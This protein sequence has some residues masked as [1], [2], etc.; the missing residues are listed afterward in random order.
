[1][2]LISSKDQQMLRDLFSERLQGDVTITYFTQ[3]ESI[4]T[5]PGQECQFCKDTRELLEEVTGLSDKLHLRVQDFV[6][7]AQA[8][9]QL[10]VERIPAFVLAGRARGQVRYFGIPSGYEFS[11]L[12]EDLLDIST[13]R[14]Q[15]S[16]QTREALGGLEQDLRIQVFVTPT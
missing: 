13:G 15:L 6:R 5:V 10:E 12:I 3:R 2:A 1:M 8:A 7:D 9:E 16:D 11:S 14:T 4:L